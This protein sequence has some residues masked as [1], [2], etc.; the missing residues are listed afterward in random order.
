MIRD[1]DAQL[2][3]YIY[4]NLNISNYGG[5]VQRANRLLQELAPIL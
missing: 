5:F 4:V 3:G 1:E 2:T